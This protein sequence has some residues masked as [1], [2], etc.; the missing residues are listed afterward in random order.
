MMEAD[1]DFNGTVVVE[2]GGTISANFVHF[3]EPLPSKEDDPAGI[4][5]IEPS[6]PVAKF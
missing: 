1:F 4:F 2:V 6:R 3:V 5:A